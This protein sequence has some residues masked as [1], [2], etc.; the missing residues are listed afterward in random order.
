M[1]TGENRPDPGEQRSGTREQHPAPPP[2]RSHSEVR[3]P[4]EADTPR[5]ERHGR[6]RHE[7]PTWQE[8]EAPTG[9]EH[10][11]PTGWEGAAA[12]VPPPAPSAATGRSA[13]P[14]DTNV[15]WRRIAQYLFDSVVSGIGAALAYAVFIPLAATP[16]GSLDQPWLAA[17]AYTVFTVLTVA[18]FLAYWVLVPIMSAK[19]Q[20]L[21]M[22]LMGIRIV[23]EDGSR[24]S[25][26]RHF[27]RVLLFIV[28]GIL[29]GLVGLVV[30]LASTRRQ[31]V[32]DMVA[33][34]LVVRAR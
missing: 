14:G 34:T 32:G 1:S 16:D 4:T 19:G 13:E 15:V 17:L 3:P 28:D 27:V 26:I 29:A 9:R 10:G 18:I 24:V 23:R 31:R 5:P 20:T 33:E 11:T 22:M 2:P 7:A 25:G 30:V 8:S 6:G 21:G 12:P